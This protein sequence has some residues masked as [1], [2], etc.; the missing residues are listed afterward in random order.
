[1]AVELVELT[2]ALADVED[3]EEL[4]VVVEVVVVD[5][6]VEVVVVDVVVVDV[7]TTAGAAP[8]ELEELEGTVEEDTCKTLAQCGCTLY[9][10][11]VHLQL[12]QY[13]VKQMQTR[14]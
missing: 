9:G 14:I 12:W 11:Q 10:F 1:M 7:V 13:T 2:L 3:D 5:V 6:V 4:V 8:V